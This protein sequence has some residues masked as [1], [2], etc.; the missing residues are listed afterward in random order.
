MRENALWR[1]IRG[2]L[3][4]HLDLQ[5]VESPITPG[6]PD[7]NY[8][9]GQGVEGWIE[10]KSGDAPARAATP[11]FKSQHGVSPAQVE[12]L[13]RRRRLGGRAWLLAKV[14]DHLLL[15]DGVFAPAFND[16]PLGALIESATWSGGKR[17][18]KGDWGRL[19]AILAPPI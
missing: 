3:G 8:C 14:G 15:L 6:L 17:L 18:D 13:V 11:V 16:L 12:W 7:V 9:S 5:R 2:P 19:G 1:K 4:E 10:L